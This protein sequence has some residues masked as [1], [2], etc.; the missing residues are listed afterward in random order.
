MMRNIYKE[1]KFNLSIEDTIDALKLMSVA[2]I[3]CCKEA[4]WLEKK[5]KEINKILKSKKT[6]N[7]IKEVV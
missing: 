4:L 2:A 7:E 1:M 3:T 5:Y 6:I